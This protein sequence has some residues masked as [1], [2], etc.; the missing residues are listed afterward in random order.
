MGGAG[1]VSFI[2]ALVGGGYPNFKKSMEGLGDYII[3]TDGTLG[4]SH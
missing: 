2:V 1:A 3:I 4:P